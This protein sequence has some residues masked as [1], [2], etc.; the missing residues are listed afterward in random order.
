MPEALPHAV[1][2]AALLDPA[3]PAPADPRFAVH[4]NNVVAGLIGALG[5]TYPAVLRLVGE[6]FFAAMAGVFVRAHPPE[7][8]VLI[9]WG[10]A[11]P[12]WLAGFA[13]AAHL[14]Y[15]ADVARLEWAWTCAFNAAEA[16]PLAPAALAGVPPERLAGVL[17]VPHPS[18]RLVA[19]RYPVASLWAE[20][21]GR[22]GA[23]VDM[24]RAETALVARP[25]DAVMVEALDPAHAAALGLFVQGASLGALAE[26]VGADAFPGLLTFLFDRGLVAALEPGDIRWTA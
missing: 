23:P 8:P 16:E 11:F 17:P 13:P 14:P 7:S 18:L 6:A 4:R 1:L 22:P 25:D 10:G 26:A 9:A 3:A 24:A 15:L 19:S 2:A 12:G 21:T 5:E 20:V